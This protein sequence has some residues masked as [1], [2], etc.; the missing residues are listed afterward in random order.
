MGL[1]V[2]CQDSRVLY[3]GE[4]NNVLG[5]LGKG[6]SWSH[7]FGGVELETHLFDFA[8][9]PSSVFEIVRN[10]ENSLAFIRRAIEAE[11]TYEIRRRTGRW[12]AEQHEIHFYPALS[13][14][15]YVCECR[16]FVLERIAFLLPAFPTDL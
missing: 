15:A 10:D 2:I 6:H 4:S 8:E 13:S 12:P 11:V 1:Y 9:P 3:V 14:D 7:K 16:D 5:K